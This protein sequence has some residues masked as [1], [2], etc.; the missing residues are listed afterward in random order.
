[1]RKQAKSGPS[2]VGPEAN[3]AGFWLSE[4]R[5]F[6]FGGVENLLHLRQKSPQSNSKYRQ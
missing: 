4:G 6:A 2:F 5:L 3:D 1:M